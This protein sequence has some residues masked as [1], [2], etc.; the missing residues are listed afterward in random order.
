MKNNKIWVFR[1]SDGRWIFGTFDKKKWFQE[2]TFNELPEEAKK[3]VIENIE[4]LELLKKLA[5]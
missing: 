3:Q 5:G 4:E 1:L 2:C